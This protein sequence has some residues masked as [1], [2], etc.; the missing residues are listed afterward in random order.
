MLRLGRMNAFHIL[1]LPRRP[2]CRNYCFEDEGKARAAGPGQGGRGRQAP[3]R[4]PARGPPAASR[5]C[6]GDRKS[7]V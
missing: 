1:L 3:P 6:A 4:P 2:L 5:A 7:V